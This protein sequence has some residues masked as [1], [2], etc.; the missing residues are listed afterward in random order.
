[1]SPRSSFAHARQTREAIVEAGL[2]IASVE[3]L[4]GLTIGR[5]AADL[6]LSKSGVL[7]HFGSKETLQLEVVDAAAE[8]F[9]REVVGRAERAPEGLRRLR[10][11][12]ESWVS[13]V[14]RGVLPGGCFFTAAASEFDDRSGPVRNAVAGLAWVWE[15]DLRRQVD[16]AVA[17]GELPAGTDSDQV[18]FELS[19]H[20]LALNYAL[21]LHRDPAAPA[22]ARTAIARLLE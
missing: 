21:R 10:A 8:L 22:R 1:M 17:A 2:R 14:E 19:G 4:E 11:L 18:V 3:G 13:Y 5:L 15:R 9:G 12:V 6:G 16:L 20:L 7:G